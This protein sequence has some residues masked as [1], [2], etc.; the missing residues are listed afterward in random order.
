[1]KTCH[2]LHEFSRNQL[3]EIRVMG[4]LHFKNIFSTYLFCGKEIRFASKR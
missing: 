2:E 3:I 1:M 4:G